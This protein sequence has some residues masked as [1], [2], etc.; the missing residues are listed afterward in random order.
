MDIQLRFMSATSRFSRRS[1]GSVS[2]SP[3]SPVSTASAESDSLTWGK[4]IAYGFGG[5]TDRLGNQGI[6]DLGNPLYN[7]VLG[8]NPATI[9]IVFVITRPS[10]APCLAES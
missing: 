6:K 3:P 9:S 2:P 1:P 5:M 8:I 10:S 7:L 4:R